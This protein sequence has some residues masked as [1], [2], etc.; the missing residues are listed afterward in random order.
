MLGEKAQVLAA[1]ELSRVITR[2][3]ELMS[4]LFIS[5]IYNLFIY[6]LFIYLLVVA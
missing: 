6:N 5:I 3:M 1:K 2:E 4:K